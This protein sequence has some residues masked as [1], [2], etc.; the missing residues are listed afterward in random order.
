MARLMIVVKFVILLPRKIRYRKREKP[1]MSN[2]DPKLF[3]D[4]SVSL[5]DEIAFCAKRQ[6][7]TSMNSLVRNAV[8]MICRAEKYMGYDNVKKYYSKEKAII[9]M[10]R[11]Y[12]FN[13]LTLSEK[14]LLLLFNNLS[15]CRTFLT[16]VRPKMF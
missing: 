6:L 4:C 3:L 1:I 10:N 12:V 5:F 15:V 13:H 11:R 2:Q 9:R 14:C 8:Y 16:V 7:E